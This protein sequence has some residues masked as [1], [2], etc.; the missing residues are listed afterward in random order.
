MTDE[1]RRL[2]SGFQVSQAI[3]VAVTLGIPDLL[4]D[5]PR[6]SDELAAAT[7]TN[8]DALYRLLRALASVGVLREH[9]ERRFESTEL[10]DRLRGPG[11]GFAA[12]IGRP[13]F[14]NAWAH[15]IESVRTGEN[16]FRLQH[17]VDVWEYRSSRPEESAIFDRAMTSHTERMHRSLVEAYDFGRFSVVVDVGGGRGTLLAALLAEHPHLQGVLFDQPHVVAGADVP[18]R[19]R[20]V[21]GNFFESVPDGG[22]AYVLKW[23]VH[24]WEDEEATAILRTVRRALPS[25]G[26]VLLVERDL[27]GPNE[28]PEA[29]LSDLNML[30]MPGGRER[31]IEEYERLLQAADFAFV[32]VTQ[33]AGGFQVIEAAPA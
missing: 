20:V 27:G 32:G 19:C 23:I 30:V 31:T 22:D 16:A 3:S 28:A 26:V 7:D 10:G 24:D 13:Y 5:S 18:D 9:A 33:V 12:L 2:V 17:G 14:W 1:L 6:T 15:L 29:K 21:G 4:A 8:P 11:G 25:H